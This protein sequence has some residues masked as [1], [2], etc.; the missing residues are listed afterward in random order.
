MKDIYNVDENGLFFQLMSTITLYF[1]DDD[2][3][4]GKKHK[5]FLSILLCVNADDLENMTPLVIGKSKKPR[6]FKNV[7]SLPL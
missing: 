6:C 7:I 5:Y 4:G 3:R 1:K 2:R